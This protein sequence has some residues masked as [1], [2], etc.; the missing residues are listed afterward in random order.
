[1]FSRF[2]G[3]AITLLHSN[4]NLSEHYKAIGGQFLWAFIS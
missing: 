2:F 4:L 1:M 3:L